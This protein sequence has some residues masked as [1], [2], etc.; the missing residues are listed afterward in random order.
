MSEPDTTQPYEQTPAP[1]KSR[2]LWWIIG[3]GA[4]LLYVLGSCVKGGIDLYKA[5][6]AR[7]AATEMLAQRFMDEGLPPADDPVYARRAGVEQGSLD[8]L[9]RFMKQFGK[10]S[11]FT[12]ASCN[13][14][15][16]AHSDPAQSGT[17]ANCTLA[18]KAELSPVTIAVRWVREDETWKLLDF[19]THFTDNTVLIDKAEKLDRLEAGEEAPEAGPQ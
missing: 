13:I 19:Q 14:V 6:T 12:P 17:F 3:G 9:N 1:R 2:R 5:V 15:T 16:S 4:L 11:E 10:V 8:S 7:N 18:A